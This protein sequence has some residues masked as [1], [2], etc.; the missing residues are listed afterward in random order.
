MSARCRYCR[1]LGA[2]LRV[3]PG[4][5]A[6]PRCFELAD[7][8]DENLTLEFGRAFN[9]APEELAVGVR[10][11]PVQVAV[12]AGC[13]EPGCSKPAARR[14]LCWMHVKREQLGR[15]ASARAA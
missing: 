6:H 5:F 3:A 9:F 12:V 15:L 13:T 10:A 1:R 4:E 11:A 8:A 2:G 14:G 7:I